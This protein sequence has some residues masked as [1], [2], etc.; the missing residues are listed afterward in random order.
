M[1]NSTLSKVWNIV[2]GK[3][4]MG[5]RPDGGGRDDLPLTLCAVAA[6]GSSAPCR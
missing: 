1:L 5:T 3:R 4:F 6:G 2:S